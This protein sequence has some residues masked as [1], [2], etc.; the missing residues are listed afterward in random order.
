M[1]ASPKDPVDISTQQLIARSVAPACLCWAGTDVVTL[2]WPVYHS[3]LVSILAIPARNKLTD[4]VL[5]GYPDLLRW[6]T[7]GARTT[8]IVVVLLAAC[9]GLLS[10]TAAMRAAPT[11][12]GKVEFNNFCRTC[13]SLKPD[14]NRLG[15]SLHGVVG[16]KAGH[17]SGYGYSQSLRQSGVTWDEAT[18]ERWIGN[19]DAVIP[20]NNM[21]PY[22]GIPDAAVRK[23][24]VDFLKRNSGGS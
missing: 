16:S 8:R 14:D 4:V 6:Y 12:D 24:I 13:H 21:K 23:R 15:P 1:H 2:G 17:S 19:P 9:V 5:T 11:E 10:F 18:L 3:T 20:S 22:S 7:I